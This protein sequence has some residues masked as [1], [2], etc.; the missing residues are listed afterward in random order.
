MA[1][2]ADDWPITAATLPFPGVDPQG[3]SVNEADASHWRSV[4]DEIRAAGFTNVDLFDNWIKPGDLSTQRLDELVRTAKEAGLGLPAISAV[5]RSVMDAEHGEENL[6]YTHR[7]LEAAAAMGA[8]VV[9]VGLHQAL[10]PEQ[11]KQLWFW[12]V[13]GYKSPE[14]DRDAWNLTVKRLQELGRHAEE[15]GL[16]ISLEMYEDTY[17]GTADSTVALVKDIGLDNVGIN[18]DVGNLVRLHRPIESWLE[19]MEKTLPY[20]NYWHVKNYIR[21]EDVARDH[22]VAMPTS[23]ELGLINYRKS[24][25]IAIANGYQGMICTEHYGGDGLSVSSTN[26]QYL[27]EKVLP[28]TSDYALGKSQVRQG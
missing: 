19:I 11:Q 15:L 27:R 17:I 25:E 24:I 10:T 28:R 2:T 5:R 3:R 14:G 9:S 6:A 22:Y 8:R 7:T 1:Y 20:A 26:Q 16:L 12:T 18:P 21:D 4:F 23:L 13:E